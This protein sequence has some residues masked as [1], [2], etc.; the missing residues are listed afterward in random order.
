MLYSLHSQKVGV[1]AVT[2]SRSSYS[3]KGSGMGSPK[4]R[5]KP[6]RFHTNKENVAKSV[7][8]SNAASAKADSDEEAQEVDDDENEYSEN[9][10]DDN[11][12]SFVES[13]SPPARTNTRTNARTANVIARDSASDVT[14]EKSARE[15]GGKISKQLGSN[16]SSREYENVNEVN[17]VGVSIFVHVFSHLLIVH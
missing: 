12:N 13:Q 10:E 9:F 4:N 7:V 11:D 6:T 14:E 3:S 1:S 5:L 17:E 2:E 15:T 16:A 8:S